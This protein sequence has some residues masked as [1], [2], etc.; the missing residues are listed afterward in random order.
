MGA[1]LALALLLAGCHTTYRYSYE[2]SVKGEA[3]TKGKY[4]LRSCRFIWDGKEL[5]EDLTVEYKSTYCKYRFSREELDE[6]QSKM[7]AVFSADG[8]PVDVIIDAGYDKR[9]QS[10]SGIFCL[11]S[12]GLI[13]SYVHWDEEDRIQL[14]VVEDSGE[15]TSDFVMAK[16]FRQCLSSSGLNR[17]FAYRHRTDVRYT[18]E[19]GVFGVITGEIQERV[20]CK[21]EAY[22]YAIAATLAQMER[23]GKLSGVTQRQASQEKTEPKA[24]NPAAS[25]RLLELRQLLDAGVISEAEYS[26][27]VKRMEPSDNGSGASSVEVY[28]VRSG[29]T[30]RSIADACG[31]TVQQLK[32]LNHLDSD[33]LRV[34]QKIVV[35]GGK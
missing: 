32:D 8:V 25:G 6:I 35:K 7:P 9:E 18:C 2:P 1:G 28:F 16:E 24:K 11:F 13:P 15:Q 31:M 5:P 26:R 14:L 19:G 27:E 21:I 29:D 34:G 17:M 10:A 23:D 20:A 12:L 3:K 30:L 4:H 33:R 22:A